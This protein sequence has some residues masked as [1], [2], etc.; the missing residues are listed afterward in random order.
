MPTY[1]YRCENNHEHERLRRIRSRN[2]SSKCP[3][4]SGAAIRLFEAFAVANTEDVGGK[5]YANLEMPLGRK[6]GSAKEVDKYLEESGTRQVLYGRQEKGCRK[7][8][9]LQPEELA[10]FL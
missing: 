5:R 6:F 3:E 4:C 8:S 10:E 7:P 1:T 9:T 2:R